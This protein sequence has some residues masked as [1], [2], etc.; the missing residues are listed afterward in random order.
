MRDKFAHLPESD[1]QMLKEFVQKYYSAQW[2]KAVD[3]VESPTRMC[4]V[5]EVKC[6]YKPLAELKDILLITGK[7]NV[8]VEFTVMPIEM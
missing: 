5:M 8:P 7:Y 1:R 6:T 4:K 3:I 2:F